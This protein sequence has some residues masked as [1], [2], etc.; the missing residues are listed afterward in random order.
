VPASAL[1]IFSDDFNA[2]NYVG[3]NPYVNFS[4]RFGPTTYYDINDVNGWTFSAGNTFLAKSASLDGA[5]LL[6]E[7]DGPLT[8]GGSVVSRQLTGLVTG[9]VYT[10]DFLLSGDNIPGDAYALKVTLGGL[11]PVTF[12]GIDGTSGSV[13][14]VASRLSFVATAPTTMLVFASASQSAASPM[15]DNVTVSTVPEPA[16]WALMIAGFGLVGVVMRHRANRDRST[17]AY[18]R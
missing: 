2:S 10:L 4:D 9:R 17:Q 3:G 16:S 15:I 12:H 13:A 6:N 1:V 5:I 11:A 14:G 8:P 18:N 7:N